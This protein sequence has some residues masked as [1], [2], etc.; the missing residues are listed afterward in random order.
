M[1]TFMSILGTYKTT[2]MED[3]MKFSDVEKLDK[4]HL[5]DLE[6]KIRREGVEL[7]RFVRCD[8]DGIAV[9]LFYE[10]N[11]EE[12]F[13]FTKNGKVRTLRKLN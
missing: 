3:F 4:E 1:Y 9:G 8:G 13:I 5:H 7:D 10:W 12:Y 6:K 11:T 2:E